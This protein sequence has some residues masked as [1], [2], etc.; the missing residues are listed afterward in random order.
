[1]IGKYF[2]FS[3]SLFGETTLFDKIEV[4]ES[5]Q[6]ADVRQVAETFIREEGLSRFYMYPKGETE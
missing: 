2:Q 6:L 1:M 5:I 4:I 3:Q